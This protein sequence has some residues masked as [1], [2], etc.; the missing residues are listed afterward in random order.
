MAKEV[1]KQMLNTCPF[2][3]YSRH[4]LPHNLG[5]W[6]LLA[7]ERE[8]EQYLP[9]QHFLT[10]VPKQETLHDVIRQLADKLCEQYP[11]ISTYKGV[12]GGKPHLKGTRFTVADVL[13]A[14]CENNSIENVIEEYNQRF[15]EEQLKEAIEFARDFLLSTYSLP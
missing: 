11:Q 4:V 14:V 1:K 5:L 3:G 10:D 8:D 7:Y 12:F 15:T 2:V 6:E 9:K 13:S